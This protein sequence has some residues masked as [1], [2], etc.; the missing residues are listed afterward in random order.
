[1]TTN[2]NNKEVTVIISNL[3]KNFWNFRNEAYQISLNNPDLMLAN[4]NL[5][6]GA[7]EMMERFKFQCFDGDLISMTELKYGC[8]LLFPRN[9]GEE[10][11]RPDRG[12]GVLIESYQS[13]YSISIEAIEEIQNSFEERL[14]KLVKAFSCFPNNHDS[15]KEI[16]KSA[17]KICEELIFPVLNSKA[18]FSEI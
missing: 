18:V 3:R 17:K 6:F 14:Q 2:Q 4:N 8:E 10:A 13:E 16:S 7:G 5:F 12:L 15:P 1:M 11:C 9:F